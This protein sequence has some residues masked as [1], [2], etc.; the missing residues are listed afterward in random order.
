MKKLLRKILT[1]N[2]GGNNMKK[3]SIAKQDNLYKKG[4][5]LAEILITLAVVGVIAAITLPTLITNIQSNVKASRIENIIQKLRHSTDQLKALNGDINNFESS[6]D[7]INTLSRYMKI[8]KW[9]S[10]KD[11][12]SC[13][14]YKTIKVGTESVD[15]KDINS[16]KSFGLNPDNW[17]APVSFLTADGTPYI[18][19]YKK[20]CD[21]EI[22]NTNSSLLSCIS[23]IFD[24]NGTGNP[25]KFETKLDDKKYTNSDI[26]ILGGVTKLVDA[27]I[28]LTTSNGVKIVGTA[29]FLNNLTPVDCSD[30]TSDDYKYCIRGG[31]TRGSMAAAIKECDERGGKLATSDDIV[32]LADWIYD[33]DTPFFK[34]FATYGSQKQNSN[35]TYNATKAANIGLSSGASNWIMSSEPIF[36]NLG[37]GFCWDFG[38]NYLQTSAGY[39]NPG[40]A[41][42]VK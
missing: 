23:G 17:Y 39:G 29:M 24:Y 33:Q 21:I 40:R 37:Y 26:Q 5:T 1:R 28:L 3:R 38:P 32:K 12:A 8:T 41:I 7:F 6:E 15:V 42:C 11:I 20:E 31:K 14:P 36:E 27:S 4:F 9:C 35:N 16:A 19:S 25:N 30:A 10:A 13:Y 34:A 2:E 22:N 18:I